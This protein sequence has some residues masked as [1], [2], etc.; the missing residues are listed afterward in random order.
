MGS[1]TAFGAILAGG[2]S[3][4]MGRDKAL[5]PYSG[6]PLVLHAAETLGEVVPEVAVIASRGS[7]YDFL[8]VPV[9]EDR[10]P[11]RGPLG[12]LHAALVHAA[13]RPV[14]CLACDLPLVGP[15]LIRYIIDFAGPDAASRAA[16]VKVPAMAGRVQPL[17]GWYAPG[18]LGPVEKWL[19]QGRGKVLD[20]LE[21]IPTVQVP[22]AAD[23]PF[24]REDLL[25]N[26]N[27]EE[28]YN[29]VTRGTTEGVVPLPHH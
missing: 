29:K 13:G 10:F 21:E 6:R 17:C 9:I 25:A 14:F 11:D 27:R 7:G 18:C 19:R 5:L 2:R 3:R 23:L 22:L 28:D 24:F 16:F 8:P 20:F 26:L 12:G 15:D 1:I 4:R